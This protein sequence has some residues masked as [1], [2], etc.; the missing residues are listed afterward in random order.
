MRLP[1]L[2]QRIGELTGELAATEHALEVADEENRRLR[3]RIAVLANALQGAYAQLQLD[4]ERD[5]EPEP[6]AVREYYIDQA[7]Y[8]LNP[9][10]KPEGDECD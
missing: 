6:R 7:Y 10:H 8:A 1:D 3:A 2:A 9:D 5:A 4:Q